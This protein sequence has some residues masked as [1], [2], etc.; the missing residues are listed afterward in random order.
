M[1]FQ[2]TRTVHAAL[3]PETYG[4]TVSLGI[5]IGSSLSTWG[6]WPTTKRR[7]PGGLFVLMA[8]EYEVC[9]RCP[10]ARPV[11]SSP[12]RRGAS[13]G[14]AMPQ[15]S[16]PLGTLSGCQADVEGFRATCHGPHGLSVVARL[17]S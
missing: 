7:H 9:G 3:N 15:G 1:R 4:W 14:S 6:R 12:A 10:L 11:T 2:P 5:H 16:L 8:L 17:D 13:R